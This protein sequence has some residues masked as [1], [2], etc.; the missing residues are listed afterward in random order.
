MAVF[1]SRYGSGQALRERGDGRKKTKQRFSRGDATTKLEEGRKTPP[2]E[3]SQRADSTRPLPNTTPASCRGAEASPQ[4]HAGRPT[5]APPPFPLR[6]HPP[7][8]PTPGLRYRK[9][10]PR[11]SPG[12]GAEPGRA[13]GAA[14][15]SPQR[16]G[17]C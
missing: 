4:G 2:E 11:H 10:R 15:G 14:A 1:T 8:H 7:T 13:R 17:R 5:A 3:P 6:L 16:W 12:A 9:S